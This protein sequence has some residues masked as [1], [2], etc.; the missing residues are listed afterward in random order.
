[1][2]QGIA[3]VFLG[4]LVAT[5]AP[6]FVI[7]QEEVPLLEVDPVLLSSDEEGDLRTDISPPD[8]TTEPVDLSSNIEGTSLL[9]KDEATTETSIPSDLSES[10]EEVQTD[11]PPEEYESFNFLLTSEEEY[12]GTIVYD[13]PTQVWGGPNE[14]FSVPCKPY[15]PYGTTKTDL[16]GIWDADVECSFTH[17]HNLTATYTFDRIE[18]FLGFSGISDLIDYPA[19]SGALRVRIY[20]TNELWEKE[21]LVGESEPIEAASIRQVMTAAIC[22]GSGTLSSPYSPD[23][24][25]AFFFSDPVTLTQGEQ[26]LFELNGSDLVT[27]TQYVRPFRTYYYP[28]L[29]MMGASVST[30]PF[31]SDGVQDSPNISTGVVHMRLWASTDLEEPEGGSSVLFLPGFLGSRLYTTDGRKLWEPNGSDDIQDLALDEAGNSK[32]PVYVGDTVDRIHELPIVGTIYANLMRWLGQLEAERSISSWRPYPYDWRYDVFDVIDNGTLRENGS[33]EYLIPLVE[34]LSSDSFTEKVTIIGHSNGGLLAKAL[35]IRLAE[36][37]KEDIVDKIILVGTPQVGTPQGMLGLLH[38]NNIVPPYIALNGEA[39]TSAIT[40]PGAYALLP[41]ASYFSSS[42]MPLATFEPGTATNVY[43]DVLGEEISNLLSALAFMLNDPLTRHIPDTSDEETPHPLSSSLL[44][45]AASTHAQLDSWK[46]PK[47]TTVHE[48]AGWG[49]ATL[50]GAA[51]YTESSYSCPSGIVSCDFYETIDFQPKTTLAGDDTVLTSSALFMDTGVYFDLLQLNDQF[52]EQ[53]RHENLTESG[54]LHDYIENLF[55]FA[56]DYE[57]SLF[58]SESPT[59]TQDLISVSVHS[60]VIISLEDEAGRKTGIFPVANSDLY[61]ILEEI[62]N[63]AVKFGGEGKYVL[64]PTNGVY[65]VSIQSIG[66][67]VFTIKFADEDGTSAITKIPIGPNTSAS[68]I[69][70]NSAVEA[71]P[72]LVDEDGDGTTDITITFEKHET[73]VYANP[74]SEE[75]AQNSSGGRTNKP[76]AGEPLESEEVL[77]LQILPV[78]D[79]MSPSLHSEPETYYLT[80]DP[81]VIEIGEDTSPPVHRT[82]TASTYDAVRS[83]IGLILQSFTGFVWWVLRV[84]SLN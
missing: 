5:T 1:M 7:A 19:I 22:T 75:I 58:P 42:L 40:M 66:E 71:S 52:G 49:N 14:A 6:I 65:E 47:N 60:P 37:G 3:L 23:C 34:Q 15:A 29:Q 43:I 70:D 53:R 31:G 25:S 83:I 17:W 13:F 76:P 20:R 55:G 63:S 33:R 41:S 54:F 50:A 82:Q 10:F 79:R 48:I 18:T 78:A 32:L 38:G 9:E 57:S 8:P 11:L 62:P 73:V 77:N 46:P 27:Q 44:A 51:Y 36:V 64:V 26:Y 45:R 12:D 16:G 2:Q 56:N 74:F 35:M 84:F 81:F 69:I 21:V 24:I 67:G 4:T 28:H 30:P 72:L 68:V 59:T 39:R 80:P 61:F